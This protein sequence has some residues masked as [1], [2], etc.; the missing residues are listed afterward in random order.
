ML[1]GCPNCGG[2]KFQFRPSSA[3]E[4]A[5]TTSNPAGNSG[6]SSQSGPTPEQKENVAGG[7]EAHVEDRTRDSSTDRTATDQDDSNSERPRLSPSSK[8]WP[9]QEEPTSRP[10]PPEPSTSP[11]S[12]ESTSEP[13][14]DADP[15]QDD[16]VEIDT[17]R[18]SLGDDSTEDTAQASARSDVVSPDE[19]AAASRTTAGDDESV[20]TDESRPDQPARPS[21]SDGKVIEPSSDER[22]DLD[23]LRAELNQQFESIRIVAPGEY[24]LNLMEL[25]DRTEYIISLQEDGRYVIEVPD[26]WDTTPGGPEDS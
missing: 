24:E 17:D 11:G 9:G 6:E 7:T 12:S 3:T 23:E 25:Y 19:L 26:T 8:K 14:T 4:S 10:E 20:G 5:E 22:P 18:Q 15:T 2:N 1:S 21:D 16:A 13:R